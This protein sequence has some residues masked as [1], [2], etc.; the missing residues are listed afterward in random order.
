MRLPD[1]LVKEILEPLLHLPEF[2]F[3]QNSYLSYLS[4]YLRCHRKPSPLLV[5]KAWCRVGTPLLYHDVVL[6]SQ[7]QADALAHALMVAP[8]LGQWI[9]KLRV[10]CAFSDQ[11][12]QVIFRSC[13]R[14]TDFCVMLTATRGEVG[15]LYSALVDLNPARLVLMT[16][17]DRRRK[18]QSASMLLA[19]C[20]AV[21]RWTSLKTVLHSSDHSD[22]PDGL[23]QALARAPNLSTVVLTRPFHGVHREIRLFCA[24]PSVTAVIIRNNHHSSSRFTQAYESEASYPVRQKLRFQTTGGRHSYR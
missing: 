12:M 24:S 8:E 17:A 23:V 20:R 11:A 13:K 10:E 7:A 4:L 6:R 14:I 1:E 16:A 19:L 22:L 9:R 2:L 18:R 15:G 21:P 5:C 3:I